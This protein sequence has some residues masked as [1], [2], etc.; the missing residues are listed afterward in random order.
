MKKYNN[1]IEYILIEYY[2][3]SEN[4]F[5]T[6]K[7]ELFFTDENRERDIVNDLNRCFKDYFMTVYQGIKNGDYWYKIIIKDL[8]GLAESYN[9]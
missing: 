2:K 4:E 6:E 1:V 3:L 9:M 7:M 8:Q 5:N